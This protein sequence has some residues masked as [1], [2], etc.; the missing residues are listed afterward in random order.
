[1]FAGSVCARRCRSGQVLEVVLDLALELVL[2]LEDV[3]ETVVV[4]DGVGG[5][6]AGEEVGLLGDDVLDPLGGEV[7]VK[8]ALGEVAPE[9]FGVVSELVL[10]LL[11]LADEREEGV[12]VALFVQ[13][14]REEGHDV[15]VR[16]LFDFHREVVELFGL[17]GQQQHLHGLHRRQQL[18]HPAVYGREGEL[19]GLEGL[20]KGTATWRISSSE[21]MISLFSISCSFLVLM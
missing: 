18:A 2:V 11:D 12:V 1:M 20:A 13:L 10:V 9:F 19:L 14:Q 21:F 17:A 16:P 4:L 15:H 3:L 6:D 7:L 8:F 5:V